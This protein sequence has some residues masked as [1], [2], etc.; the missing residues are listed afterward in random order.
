MTAEDAKTNGLGNLAMEMLCPRH[1]DAHAEQI[2][3]FFDSI[4]GDLDTKCGNNSWIWNATC[5]REDFAK[6]FEVYADVVNNPSFP[7]PEFAAMK[8]RV[9]AAI[10]QQDADW[11]QQAAAVLQEIVSSAR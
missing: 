11:T 5:L 7:E 10:A 2:A 3:E 4:G 1:Q 6:A 9:G 8:K